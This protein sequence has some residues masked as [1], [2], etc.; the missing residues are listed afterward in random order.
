MTAPGSG[1]LRRRRDRRSDRSRVCRALAAL[2]VLLATAGRPARGAPPVAGWPVVGGDPGGSRYSTLADIDRSNVGRLRV[3]WKYR[4]GDYRGGWPFPDTR[5][6]AFQTTPIVV[7]GLLAFTTPYNRVIALD[8]ETGAERWT[9]DPAIDRNGL[10]PNMMINR[11][12]AAWREANATAPCASR[13]YLATL[14]ARLIALD[15]RTGTPCTTFGAGG[16]VNLR[17]GITPLVDPRE[18]YVTSSPTVVGD[19]VVVGSAIADNIRRIQPPGAV[20]A[21][22]ARTG[23]QAWRFNTVPQAREAGV[24]TWEEESWREAG[25]ANVWSTMTADLERGLVFLPVSTAG[26][27]FYGGDRPGANLFSDAVVALD[28]RTGRRAW[29]FQTVHHDLWDYDLAAPPNLVR[30]RGVDAVAQATKTGFVFLLE[31]DTGRPLFAVHERP[32]PASD[33]PGERA[34]PTQPVPEKPPP[35]V[36]QRLTEADLWD[37]D[38]S[39]RERCLQRLRTLRNDGLFTPPSVRGSVLYPFTGGGANWSGAAFDP[40]GQV[41]FVPT[42]NLVHTIRLDLLPPDNFLTDDA[43][44]GRRSRPGSGTPSPASGRACDTGCSATSSRRTGCP[45][46][47]RRGASSPPSIWRRE[48]YA[49]RCRWAKTTACTAS[50][51]SARRSPPRVESC[52]TPGRATSGCG[53]TMPRRVTCSPPSRCRLPCTAASSPTSSAPTAS[54]SWSSRPAATR[55]SAPRSATT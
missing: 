43:V 37:A 29:H 40:E 31:R 17:D 48:R 27:D 8:P 4:H 18:Y 6:T 26:P 41:L 38:P 22:D 21:Y 42:N 28:A 30:V 15:T 19:N 34:W 35:L 13:V 52:F 23:V 1:G 12:V 20:R 3:A 51:T 24:E 25:C 49:G 53:R 16:T 45:A 5:G 46:T 55:S 36:P 54:S 9:F 2:V 11:G 44:L 39:H 14:D 33:V 50:R 7:D 10:F 47:S 32:V